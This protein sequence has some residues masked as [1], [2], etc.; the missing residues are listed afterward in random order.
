MLPADGQE[1]SNIAQAPALERPF[2]A[3]AHMV[4]DRYDDRQHGPEHLDLEL[5]GYIM[6]Y[7]SRKL[8]LLALPD[9]PPPGTPG[10]H[11]S[12]SIT[13]LYRFRDEVEA[14]NIALRALAVFHEWGVLS[15]ALQ[16]LGHQLAQRQALS[17]RTNLEPPDGPR[18]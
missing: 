18:H 7:V 8:D 14:A 2:E 17:G 13:G 15:A 10:I 6:V 1:R 12:Q 16:G 11:P 9:A 5:G 3:T 4:L